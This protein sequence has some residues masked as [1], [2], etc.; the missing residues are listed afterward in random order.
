MW[1]PKQEKVRKIFVGCQ[2]KCIVYETECKH[3]VVQRGKQDQNH[4]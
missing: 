2:K 1:G 4:L 3:V